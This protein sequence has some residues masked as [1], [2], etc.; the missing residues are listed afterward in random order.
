MAIFSAQKLRFAFDWR[1]VR[2]LGRLHILN[3]TSVLLVVLVPILVSLW[4]VVQHALTWYDGTIASIQTRVER[5]A[6]ALKS[7][8]SQDQA[9][10]SA[11]TFG[12]ITGKVQSELLAL[13]K[14]LTEVRLRSE[15]LFPESLALLFF[16]S[17]AVLLGQAT[18]QLGCPDTVKDVRAD[19]FIRDRKRE[20]AEA[21]STSA[22][23]RAIGHLE[24]LGVTSILAAEEREEKIS[25]EK[26]ES[27]LQERIFDAEAEYRKILDSRPRATP[28]SEVTAEYNRV[29]RDAAENVR[30]RREEYGRFKERDRGDRGPEF[31]RRM[32]LIELS[33]THAYATEAKR[34]RPAMVL[35]ALLY[36]AAL[37]LLGSVIAKQSLAVAR[38]AGWI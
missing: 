1:L 11:S 24:E 28:G 9:N 37:W 31:R 35:C 25:L 22:V 17:L 19:E 32:A 38:A 15:A 23:D 2:G 36:A 14:Q 30:I 21:P 3:R 33:A 7:N 10:G 5:L 12:V 13:Q 29:A 4:P 6:G 34:A 8:P 26:E 16:A 20:Y 18:F 27:Q